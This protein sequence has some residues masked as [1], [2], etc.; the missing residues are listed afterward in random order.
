MRTV[1]FISSHTQC[2]LCIMNCSMYVVDNKP[3]VCSLVTP[4][5]PWTIQKS[6]LN[7]TH[8]RQCMD[9]DM[10][11]LPVEKPQYVFGYQPHILQLKNVP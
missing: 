11:N 3:M 6:N 8:E 2:V 10:Y 1:L 9:A 5:T 4:K 7:R